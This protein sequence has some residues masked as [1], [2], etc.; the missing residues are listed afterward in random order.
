MMLSKIA[1]VVALAACVSA[2]YLSGEFFSRMAMRRH[3]PTGNGINFTPHELPC[4]HRIS[5]Q[6]SIPSLPVCPDGICTIGDLD[7]RGDFLRDEQHNLVQ[8]NDSMYRLVRPDINFT[9]NGDLYVAFFGTPSDGDE[10]VQNMYPSC[11]VKI[12]FYDEYGMFYEQT[13]FDRVEDSVFFDKKCKRYYFDDSNESGLYVTDDNYILGFIAVQEDVQVISRV[14]FTL[15]TP[16]SRFVLPESDVPGC[17]S[18][19]YT[20]PTGDVCADDSCMA[21]AMMSFVIMTIAFT[22]VALV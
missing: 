16:L 13:E 22:L 15:K 4:S 1:V 6:V 10:C 11:D 18:T 7:V 17:N 5:F 2:S 8:T 14:S 21:K 20:A 12:E 3:N 19:A 9:E